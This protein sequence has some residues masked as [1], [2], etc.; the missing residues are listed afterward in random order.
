MFP[1]SPGRTL[2]VDYAA[3]SITISAGGR[4]DIIDL[5]V[6]NHS[7]EP[8]E[9][10][11]LIYPHAIP[12][13]GD[14]KASVSDITKTLLEDASPYNDLHFPEHTK[15]RL[16]RSVQGDELTITMIDP[17]DVTKE[18]P[19]KGMIKGTQTLTPYHVADADVL[20]SGEWQILENLA[21]SAF[22]ITFRFPL[23]YE[24]AR[25]LRLKATTGML[26]TNNMSPLERVLRRH[27]GILSDRFEIAG[28]LDVCYRL[29]N[30]I[31]AAGA[32]HQQISAE[33]SNTRLLLHNLNKK[34]VDDGLRL[35]RGICGSGGEEPM[36]LAAGGVEGALLLV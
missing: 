2:H 26:S 6:T 10:I 24:E 21:W 15:R 29:L 20:T 32:D 36:E 31:K 9:R 30:V 19:Y 8:I 3:E 18:L 25:W 28:P 16:E 14:P 22:T 5:L 17:V 11:H 33:D 27:L 4:Q 23:V 12:T 7:T 34:L 13:M 35:V 1:F